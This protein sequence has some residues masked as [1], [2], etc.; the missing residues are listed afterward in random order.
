MTYCNVGR[1]W[2]NELAS[3]RDRVGLVEDENENGDFN[4]LLGFG[5]TVIIKGSKLT[6]DDGTWDYNALYFM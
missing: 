2:L 5:E 1:V 6:N 4:I 3:G